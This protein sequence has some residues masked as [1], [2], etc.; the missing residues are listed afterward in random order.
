MESP[1][2]KPLFK[3]LSAEDLENLKS[4]TPQQKKKK[5]DILDQVRLRCKLCEQGKIEPSIF[6]EA[7]ILF[8]VINM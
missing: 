1:N 3:P 8:H 7:D 5:V 4:D 6:D 2:P